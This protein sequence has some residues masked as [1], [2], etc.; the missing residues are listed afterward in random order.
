MAHAFGRGLRRPSITHQINPTDISVRV[1]DDCNAEFWLELHLSPEELFT[2]WVQ[3]QIE[4]GPHR[5]CDC[6]RQPAEDDQAGGK[7]PAGQEPPPDPKTKL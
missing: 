7:P 6:H 5:L 3:Y 4:H 2:W 1:D